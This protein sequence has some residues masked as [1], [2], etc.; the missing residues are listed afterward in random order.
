M[1]SIV[2]LFSLYRVKW[3]YG[4]RLGLGPPRRGVRRSRQLPLKLRP[5]P[6]APCLVIEAVAVMSPVVGSPSGSKRFEK[7]RRIS[8]RDESARHIRLDEE[9]IVCIPGES[10]RARPY[11]LQ[12]QGS[13]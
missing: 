2:S 1:A 11:P 6:R 10:G 4:S 12:P 13:T 7:I 5:P 8:F 3:R 9:M